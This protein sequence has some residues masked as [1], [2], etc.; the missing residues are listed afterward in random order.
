MPQ[1]SP[2][3]IAEAQQAQLFIRVGSRLKELTEEIAQMD[4][5]LRSLKSKLANARTERDRIRKVL[6]ETPTFERRN[7]SGQGLYT[8]VRY[9][10]PY[11]ETWLKEYNAVNGQGAVNMLSLRSG[12]HAHT[13]RSYRT[14][15]ISYIGILSADRLLTAIG[16][17]A[18]LDSL[19]LVTYAEVTTRHRPPQPP[20]TQ[21]YEE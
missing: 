7:G 17:D 10:V 11:I 8:H 2:R 13:I 5:Q 6:Y 14:G 1:P 9:I 3:Q 18:I 15:V 20:P 21:F 4:A 19:P 16:K 12:V